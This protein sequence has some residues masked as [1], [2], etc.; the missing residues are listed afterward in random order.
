M[1]ELLQK[2]SV[3]VQS[4]EEQN[5]VKYWNKYDVDLFLKNRVEQAWSIEKKPK[6]VI[7]E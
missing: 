3:H 1:T 7:L 5:A 4:K 6:Q 2:R